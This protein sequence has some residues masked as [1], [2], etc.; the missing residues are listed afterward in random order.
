MAGEVS[1]SSRSDLYC[2]LIVA[3]YNWCNPPYKD[4]KF[5]GYGWMPDLTCQAPSWSYNICMEGL[6]HSQCP[7]LPQSYNPGPSHTH[8][9]SDLLEETFWNVS[10]VPSKFART[11][12]PTASKD[13]ATMSVSWS[14]SLT[15]L[16]LKW[17]FGCAPITDGE[18][19]SWEEGQEA[20]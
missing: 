10:P 16:W 7:P 19:N 6:Y 2:T 13:G 4:P 12:H 15:Q 14:W 20:T 1:H 8:T 11:S 5:N 18:L 9:P 3:E 17:L